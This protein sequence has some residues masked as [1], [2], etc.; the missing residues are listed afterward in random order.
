MLNLIV[1]TV[2]SKALSTALLMPAPLLPARSLNLTQAIVLV[3]GWLLP[4]L[5]IPI[6]QVSLSLPP[7]S[8]PHLYDAF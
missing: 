4:L 5:G 6:T 7:P 1:S 3:P 2:R 8:L